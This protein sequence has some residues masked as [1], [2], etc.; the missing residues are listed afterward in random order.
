MDNEVP[1][2]FSQGPEKIDF[3]KLFGRFRV[4]WPWIVGS[5]VLSGFGGFCYLNYVDVVYNASAK[6][7]LLE[8][9]ESQGIGVDV[10][11][12]L[13]KSSVNL[14][15]EIAAFTSLRLAQQ[16]VKSGRFYVRYIDLGGFKEREVYDA[17][18][19]V[20]GDVAL[21]RFAK[22]VSFLVNISEKGFSISNDDLG[23]YKEFEGFKVSKLPIQGMELGLEMKSSVDVKEVIGTEFK[24]IIQPI[25]QA[26]IALN[27]KIT[28]TIDG[29]RSDILVI[30][31]ES[32]D[33]RHAERMVD[34]LIE[35]YAKDIIK[36]K[37]RV[38]EQTIRFIDERFLYL[39]KELDSIETGKADYKSDNELFTLESYAA[40]NLQDKREGELKEELIDQ[41]LALV[42]LLLDELQQAPDSIRVLPA[43]IGIESGGLLS[44]LQE[45]NSA[46]L[47]YER[48]ASIVSD[49]N[50]TVSVEKNSIQIMRK[51]L[52]QA[53]ESFQEQ[54]ELTRS[55]NRKKE[56]RVGMAFE[57][58]PE[59][60]QLLRE[61]ERQQGLKESLYLILLQKREEAALGIATLTPNI[62]IID[63]AIAGTVPISPIGSRVWAVCLIMGL[64]FP[65][66]IVFIGFVI[67]DKVYDKEDL[68]RLSPGIPMVGEIPFIKNYTYGQGVNDRSSLGE[69]FRVMSANLSY[70]IGLNQ[71]PG[72][73]VMLVTS[74]TQGEGKSFAAVQLAIS[75]AGLG[76]KVLLIGADVRNPQLHNYF[77]VDKKEK[78]LTDYLFDNQ[79]NGYQGYI[80]Q[81]IPE[82]KDNLSVMFTGEKSILNTATFFSQP[83]F[84]EL[85]GRLR[86]AYDLIIVDSAPTML[87]S[88]TLYLAKSMDHVLHIVRSG[89]TTKP[90]VKH[91]LAIKKQFEK[92]T[93][94]Y[95]LNGSSKSMKYGYGNN[96]GYGYGY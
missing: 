46:V 56:E 11:Q 41:Q 39:A 60:E 93:M 10:E 57:S 92:I 24:V 75:Y 25:E 21:D 33:G 20:L 27:K 95:A 37:K 22:P 53:V 71:N 15:N 81:P 38:L 84:H 12:L 43:D 62:K 82:L 90:A 91:S 54:L 3:K 79:E 28:V 34:G 23:L 64:F 42:Q 19:R 83:K 66:G 69:A 7:R 26:A 14:E 70:A 44:R 85:I 67:D 32:T 88:D 72:C 4:Y 94:Y 9:D 96:Y 52:V 61:I 65:I 1:S 89:Y 45:Y 68:E 50:P 78:G 51:A 17:P 5:L 86:S 59:K 29:E 47:E 87:V 31:A 36:D 77:I 48:L 76:K 40:T 30:D 2:F 16:T 58:L 73:S 18:F 6:I 63:K 13:G 35:E 74:S 8:R 55:N 80:Q 49:N